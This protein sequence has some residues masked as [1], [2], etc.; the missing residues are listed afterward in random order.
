MVVLS[1]EDGVSAGM[2]ISAQGVSPDESKRSTFNVQLST[3]N[4]FELLKV[5]RR[6][7]NGSLGA[8]L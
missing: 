8:W 3:L 2:E 6:G 5:E 1:Q 4:E 7:L